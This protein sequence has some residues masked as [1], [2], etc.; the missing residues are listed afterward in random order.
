MDQAILSGTILEERRASRHLIDNEESPMKK[1]FIVSAMI[2]ATTFCATHAIAQSESFAADA[3]G[4]EVPELA[5]PTAVQ[6]AQDASEQEGGSAF[7]PTLTGD[8]GGMR[9][10]L[11]SG[12]ISFE[13]SYR[14]DAI[15]HRR[16][17][18][19]ITHNLD[20][21]LTLNLEELIGWHGADVELYA[22]GNDGARP[23]DHLGI[24]QPVSS[25]ETIPDMRLYTAAL[26]YTFLEGAASVLIGLY[27][28]NSEFCAIEAASPF[29]NSSFGIGPEIAQTGQAGPS[30]FPVTSA[31]VRMMA[32]PWTGWTVACAVLD[33]V[34]GSPEAETGTHV[35]FN[36]GDGALIAA[37]VNYTPGGGNATN[38]GIGFWTYTSPFADLVECTVE[39]TA[40][41]RRDNAGVYALAEGPVLLPGV[42]AFIRLGTAN[43]RLNRFDLSVAGGL[44]VASMIMDGDLTAVGFS[45]ARSGW[46]YRFVGTPATIGSETVVELTYQAPVTPWLTVQPDL[47]LFD[48][49]DGDASR[50]MEVVGGVRVSLL[51]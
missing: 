2:T 17:A 20:L 12:G 47:Q 24:A 42:S 4:F 7:Q 49:P 1:R 31:G 43:A 8:W 37:E 25:I 5:S 35:E 44:N 48:S 32:S 41:C 40:V 6:S 27:D 34:P 21:R 38:V 19:S 23:S 11:L 28:L 14:A 15:A 45:T 9:E 26:R 46:A 50:A 3:S 30:I 13:G 18:P 29:L 16:L 10:L 39:G 36:S 33:G 22:L 51:F